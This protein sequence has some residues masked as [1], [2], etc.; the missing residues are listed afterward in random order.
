MK[1]KFLFIFTLLASV[2]FGATAASAAETDGKYLTPSQVLELNVE[3]DEAVQE[4]NK[5]LDNGKTNVEVS[6]ENVTVGFKEFDVPPPISASDGFTVQPTA[7]GSKGYQA[8]VANTNGWNFT[9]A[10]YG[11]FTWNGQKL[12]AL[13][14]T[15]DMTGVFYGKT[16]TTTVEG[17]DGQI[18]ST[19]KIGRAT[20]KGK[21]TALRYLPLSYHTTLIV[22]AYAPT[23]SFR[24]TR[25]D[26]QS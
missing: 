9:H 5:Q 15:E 4:V 13:T 21:F 22:E 14:A 10:M 12:M 20:S 18:G 7:L 16:A 23:Q 3:L 11:T 26:I 2:I 25:A 1:K 19:A 6:T 17:A 24:I 8:Y